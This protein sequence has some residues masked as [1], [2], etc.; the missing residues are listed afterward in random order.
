M[1]RCGYIFCRPSLQRDELVSQKE[2]VTLKLQ[3][4]S[5]GFSLIE[6]LVVVA[7]ISILVGVAIPQF[8]AY[9]SKAFDSK[10]KS[11]LKGAA[12]ALEA[13]YAL[14][15]TYTSNGTSLGPFGFA[16]SGGVSLTITL[17]TVNSYTLTA[18]SSGGSQPSFTFDSVTG[19]IN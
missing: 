6:L 14:N 8:L 17:P 5:A 16:S 18:V 10:M 1:P 12:L 9:R 11:D 2:A 7:I 15:R 19:S 13:Y 3:K 4:S